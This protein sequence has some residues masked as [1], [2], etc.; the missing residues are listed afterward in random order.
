MP[1]LNLKY[2]KIKIDLKS[3][4]IYRKVPYFDSSGGWNLPI[5]IIKFVILTKVGTSQV[6]NNNILPAQ[7]RAAIILLIAMRSF[8]ATQFQ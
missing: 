1:M 4:I 3:C 2:L 8:V 5:L 7:S 6:S